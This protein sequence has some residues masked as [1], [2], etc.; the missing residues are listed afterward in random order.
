MVS[1]YR[2]LRSTV[3]AVMV[4]DP[5][6]GVQFVRTYSSE[7]RPVSQKVYRMINDAVILDLTTIEL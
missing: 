3:V 4:F 5:A 2:A 7:S 6:P 1:L